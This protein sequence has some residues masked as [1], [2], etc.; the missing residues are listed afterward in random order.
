MTGTK[1]ITRS[2]PV[3]SMVF[4]TRFFLPH[5]NFAEAITLCHILSCM[6]VSRLFLWENLTAMFFTNVMGRP[7][8]LYL[9]CPNVIF[10]YFS[11]KPNFMSTASPVESLALFRLF[12][13]LLGKMDVSLL[14]FIST[15]SLMLPLLLL[16]FLIIK[17]LLVLCSILSVLCLD[18]I[19][20]LFLLYASRSVVIYYYILCIILRCCR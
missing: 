5:N 6:Y 10:F 13:L 12:R 15:M 19:L 14:N 18:F 3:Y 11:I 20:D 9:I 2:I 1:L 7:T 4:W 16:L 8:H 17:D